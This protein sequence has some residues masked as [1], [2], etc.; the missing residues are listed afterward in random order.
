MALD[1]QSSGILR[2]ATFE[3]DLRARE[4]RK[5]GKRIKVQEQ[6]FHV[7]TVLLQRPGEVVTRE[8]LRNQ[9]WPPD[10]FV[11]FDNSLNTAINKLREALGDSA[12]NPRFIET[13]PRRGY[14][15]LA[16]VSS[17][18]RKRSRSIAVKW[19]GA[20]ATAVVVVV[21]VAGGLFWHSRQARR[22]TDKD[23]IVLGEFANYTGDPVFDGTLREG[24]SVQLEQSPF[25]SLVSED[26]I[27]QTL[28][29]MERPA[30]TQLRPEITRE[31]CQRMGSAAALDGSIALIGTR[32]NLILKATNCANG[33]VLA[34]TE[35]QAND[36]SHVLDAL[37]K[38]A[39]E[40]RRKLGESL[41]STQK[42]NTPLEQATTPSLEALQAYSLGF[43]AEGAGDLSIALAFY[44]RATQID[45]KFAMAYL[46]MA[47]GFGLIGESAL[48]IENSRK[49]FSLRDRVSALEKLII[50]EEYAFY[51][52][53]DLTKALQT[54][55][56]GA[57]TYPRNF[58][59][60]EDLGQGLS[61]LGQYESGLAENLETLRLAPYR[62]A[63]YRE[64]AHTYLYLNRVDQAEATAKEARAKNLNA[65]LTDVFYGIAFYRQNTSE[66]ARQLAHAKD[67]PGE[68]DMLLALAG[69]TVAYSGHLREA[70]EFSRRAEDSAGQI[71]R[72]EDTAMYRAVSAFREAL[73]GNA[74][75]ARQLT[76]VSQGPSSGRDLDYATAL[77]FAYSGDAQR[78]R[79]LAD[80]LGKWFPEDTIVQFN[81]LPTLQAK[82]AL[83][84]ANPQEALH[85][86]ESAASYELGLPANSLYNWPNLYPVYVRGEAYLAAHQGREA[87]AEFQKI[88]DHRGIVLNEPIGALAHLQ[89][90][91][92]Y[93]LQGNTA[94]ARAAYQDFLTLWKDADSD[95]PILKQAKAEY[96]KLR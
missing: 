68:E 24:L 27:H 66:M 33:D 49:A 58:I 76:A 13:L 35:A 61:Y 26:G 70:R 54:C 30:N 57:R 81:Y 73:F 46:G 16:P 15:F 84:R 87:A 94:M 34:S 45:P 71:R 63:A 51:A 10:T 88:L 43:K 1:T 55:E 79:A 8:E 64:V 56:L 3:V 40:M 96:A 19:G 31:V 77:A 20:G 52:S 23:T 78:A 69:D 65:N 11:D 89:L 9:N 72:E 6:P 80:S 95:V 25:L 93:S 12:D 44:K 47:G 82:L 7:L 4:L 59:F 74:G 29:M 37:G 85:S 48:A 41:S 92:A 28:Q 83:L 32:Y 75:M 2:F 62:G 50:E 22:L 86:L 67:V 42:Y 91:R 17:H 90:A 39:S 53:G 18:Q 21:A 36:K 60:H 14:R 38:A 5:Q